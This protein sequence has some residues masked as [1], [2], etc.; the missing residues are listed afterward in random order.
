M[1]K[2]FNDWEPT[3][4]PVNGVMQQEP[5]IFA[6]DAHVVVI[7]SVNIT[8][9]DGGFNITDGGTLFVAGDVGST[10]T[11][12]SGTPA[13]TAT[14]DEVVAGAVTAITI[15]NRGGAYGVGDVLSFTGG[16]GSGFQIT[17]T[18]IDIPNTGERG[19][20]LYVGVAADVEVVME[21]KAQVTFKGVNAGSFLPIL[22]K[23]VKSGIA[24]TGDILALY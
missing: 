9:G 4:G 16:T 14:I 18:N 17:V 12:T 19:C 20:C 8:A 15:T 24:S 3:L 6:H 2:Q 13:L 23:E 11:A 7:G 22:V 10:L 21:G 5:R 1:R